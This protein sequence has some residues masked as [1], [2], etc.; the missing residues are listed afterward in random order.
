MQTNEKKPPAP[1]IKITGL[2]DNLDFLGTPLHVQ[3]EYLDLPEAHVSTQVF[4]Q[5]R[6]LLSRKAALPPEIC[7][8]Q[9]SEPIRALMRS[10]HSDVL[11]E[12]AEK[13]KRLQARP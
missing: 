10:Q 1:L 7:P 11:S 3:T 6:I 12:I 5:G 8:A 13:Q 9:D 2:N 4:R